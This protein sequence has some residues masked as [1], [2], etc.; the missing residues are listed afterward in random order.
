MKGYGRS[1]CFATGAKLTG[2]DDPED[3]M[4]KPTFRKA[5]GTQAYSSSAVK[6]DMKLLAMPLLHMFRYG[7][8]CMLT[9]RRLIE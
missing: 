4:P 5:T 7:Q 8:M 1:A 9:K 2:Q 6:S 3:L